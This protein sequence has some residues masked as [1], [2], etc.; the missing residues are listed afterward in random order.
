MTAL[1]ALLALVGALVVVAVP[2]ASAAGLT[3]CCCGLCCC[4][5]AL[6]RTPTL[7]AP[8]PGHNLSTGRV[9]FRTAEVEP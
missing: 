4:G 6:T 2:D 8:R 5:F 3:L 1:G 7:R 9:D